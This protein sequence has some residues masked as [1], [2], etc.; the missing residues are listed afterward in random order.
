MNT[1]QQEVRQSVRSLRQTP[2]LVAVIIVTLG[3]GLGANMA[4]F[5]VVYAVLLNAFTYPAHEPDRVLLMAE[6]SPRGSRMGVAYQTFRDWVD[7]LESF[8]V[9]S[10][11][12]NTTYTLTGTHEPIRIRA[13]QTSFTYF[14]IQGIQPLHGRLYDAEDD[15]F[16]AARVVV[17]NYPGGPRERTRSYRCA[18]RE[19]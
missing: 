4:V 8:D 1:F 5:S 14:G 9:L 7:Q 12:R 3:I 10:G 16:G 13:R 11:Y 2:V 17:L 18:G 19:Y 6:R 15:R